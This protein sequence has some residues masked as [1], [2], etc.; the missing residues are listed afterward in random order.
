[1]GIQR[2]QGVARS[3]EVYA[4]Q[5]SDR[6]LQVA[7]DGRRDDHAILDEAR[8]RLRKIQE[9]TEPGG[10]KRNHTG[11]TIY[12]W[13][14][15]DFA[16]IHKLL[17]RLLKAVPYFCF[18]GGIPQ[19]SAAPTHTLPP[20]K[21][22]AGMENFWKHAVALAPYTI[23]LT[24]ALRLLWIKCRHSRKLKHPVFSGALTTIS[25]VV[26]WGVRSLEEISSNK[27]AILFGMFL[28]FWADFVADSSRL[29]RAKSQ[30][31]LTAAFGGIVIDFLCTAL[32]FISTM[33]PAKSSGMADYVR[34]AINNGPFWLSVATILVY[35]LQ[36]YVE[37]EA[38]DRRLRVPHG[39]DDE[40]GSQRSA[41]PSQ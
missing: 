29:I 2:P 31:M 34:Q 13:L 8:R 38:N 16:G 19:A 37:R 3:N 25:A 30:Y 9:L 11:E 27:A 23:A 32:S 36:T 22:E 7:N 4:S 5:L 10:W 41:Q 24:G 14:G 1:M 17:L 40:A 33:S 18:L 39:R 12:G 21:L 26:W 20:D 28:L 6:R 35:I 15:H